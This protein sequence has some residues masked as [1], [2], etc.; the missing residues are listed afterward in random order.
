MVLPE[1]LLAFVTQFVADGI[2]KEFRESDR[3]RN[4]QISWKEFSI[5]LKSH[6]STDKHETPKTMPDLK[7]EWAVA[8]SD[9][10]S[11]LSAHE[12]LCFRHPELCKET[13]RQLTKDVVTNLDKNSDK[14]LTEEEYTAP[15]P[16]QVEEG[17]QVRFCLIIV[18]ALMVAF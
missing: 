7:E 10:N 3:D 1:S 17:F 11:V 6:P 2:A 8:D 18:L 4:S 15:P 12:F 14:V 13:L 5:W 9:H 16:G